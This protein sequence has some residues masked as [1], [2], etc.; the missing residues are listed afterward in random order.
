MPET[1][2]SPFT[3]LRRATRRLPLRLLS[4]LSLVAAA[5]AAVLFVAPPAVQGRGD[6]APRAVT[7]RGPLFADEGRPHRSVPQGLALGGAHHLAGRSAT[8][9]R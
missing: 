4:A 2:P 9:S 3:A 6:A 1:T 7:P 8:C 5:A